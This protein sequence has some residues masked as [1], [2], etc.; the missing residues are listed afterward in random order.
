MVAVHL[1]FVHAHIDFVVIKDTGCFYLLF[2][3][4]IVHGNYGLQ[5]AID[6]R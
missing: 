2:L 5:I 3:L 4:A 6:S 1:L